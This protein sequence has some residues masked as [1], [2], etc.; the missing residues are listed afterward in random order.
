[1]PNPSD[2][3]L[4]I[5]HCF[6][7]RLT[8]TPSRKSALPSIHVCAQHRTGHTSD[9]GRMHTSP[10]IEHLAVSSMHIDL[11]CWPPHMCHSYRSAAVL[12]DSAT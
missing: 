6:G 12:T 5:H 4:S 2:R 11:F 8:T 7:W 3:Q 10:R 9:L 1:M